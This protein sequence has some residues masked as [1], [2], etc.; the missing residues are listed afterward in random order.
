MAAL[1]KK[2]NLSVLVVVIILLVFF[3]SFQ[4]VTAEATST[5]GLG[6][7]T[8]KDTIYQI[9]TD[10]FYDGDPSNNIPPGFDPTL[11]DGTGTDLKLY[12][13]GDWKGI[14]EK[15]PYLKEMGITAVWISA[16][17]ANRDTVIEDYHPDGSVDRW[18]SFH[19][20]HAR[21]YFAT[22]KHFGEM[23]DFIALRD[24]LHSNGIKL[25]IDFVSNHSSRWQNPTLNYQPEDGRLYEPDKDENGNYVFDSNG[26]PADYNGDGIV[27]NLLADP[28]ND[29]DGFFHGLGDRGDDTTRFGYRYKDL[30]SLA[31][32]SQEN[33]EVVEHLEKAAIFWKSKGIDGVRH[34]ATLHMNPAFV[35]GFK[36]AID[37]A[38]GGPLTH[39]G[40]FFIGR[41][42]PKYE[43]YRT[44]P[45]RTG[46]NNLDF[47]Y[48][49][50]ATNT[51]GYF[52]ETMRDF[53][54][55]MIKTSNDYI[56]E[57]QAVTFIDN[58]DV[59][60]FRYIQPND[61]PYHAALAVLMTSRGIPNIYYGTEQYLYPADDS[62]IAG[63]MFMQT[64]TSFDQT[65]TAYKLIRK[66]SDLRKSNEAVSYG[67]TEILYSTDDVLVFKRQFYDKQ[68]IVAVNR[69][70]DRSFDVPDLNTTLPVGTYHDV[71]EGLLYGKSMSVVEENG[72]LKIKGFTLSGGEVNIWSYNPSL[73]TEIPRIGDVISTM[74]RPGNL[75]YIYG[76]G[77][78]GNVTVKFDTTLAQVVSNS[79]EMIIA[80]VPNTPGIKNITVEKG[81][82]TSNPFRYHVLSGDLV[83]VIFKVNATTEWGQNI[84]I[85]GNLPELGNWDPTL[86]T[87][88]MM[89]P[90]YPEWFLPVSVPM[91]TTFEFKFIKKDSNGNVIWE[92]GENRIFTS[93]NISTGTVDTP[94][95]NWRD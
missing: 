34:D 24:A 15:I 92:S 95:Y 46:V 79:N 74:G 44:F 73:G 29:I 81:N 4:P 67:T 3:F 65:T 36:D 84:H 2:K 63:R 86:S 26:N 35:Q 8:P 76:T 43:E 54:E 5:G 94:L 23:Q 77:L 64:S 80:V 25:V 55:M 32:Y 42:D 17:Y 7:V 90:N 27:E 37:S 69:Q 82:Y 53:G 16:P 59:T 75:I 88:A 93:P 61:K 47:E 13:G 60:R 14:I 68:V 50:A 21:N 31:D 70:P 56:Y 6:P 57:N 9:I 85:V 83:Q 58:H 91:G 10:R 87:E 19:G 28:H 41:P 22:N 33:P 20:Y 89:C 52:S 40:E 11:F 71:L 18:T 51:F 38:P 66:L 78:G 62:D 1:I 72:Q 45:D 30:G 49:R 48:Y 12:Q 39:F